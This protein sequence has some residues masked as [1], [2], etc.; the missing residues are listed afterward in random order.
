[1]KNEKQI[2]DILGASA[3]I[4]ISSLEQ[5]NAP[6]QMLADEGCKFSNW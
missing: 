1:M 5:K 2:R 6:V 3:L 4:Q